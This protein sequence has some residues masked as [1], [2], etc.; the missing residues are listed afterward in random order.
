MKYGLRGTLQEGP[1]RGTINE[2]WFGLVFC[3]LF[4][5]SRQIILNLNG[6]SLLR[7]ALSNAASKGASP[8]KGE[9]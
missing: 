3:I 5:L 9:E 8:A 6:R 2:T 7:G 1:G 4:E